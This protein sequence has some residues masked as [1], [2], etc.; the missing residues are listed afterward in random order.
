MSKYRV[1]E[2][3]PLAFR[4]LQLQR[5]LKRM[6]WINNGRERFASGISCGTTDPSLS[7]S[8]SSLFPFSFYFPL[9]FS[10]FTDS[11]R[12]TVFSFI[13]ILFLFNL[14]SSACIE[15]RYAISRLTIKRKDRGIVVLRSRSIYSIQ[16]VIFI[17][18]AS[19]FVQQIYFHLDY[20]FIRL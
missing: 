20:N 3:N 16:L 18:F 5:A 4:S 12:S 13:P 17:V 2:W 6:R 9:N 1:K 8:L 7:L 11:N 14:P 10:S 19:I 15:C